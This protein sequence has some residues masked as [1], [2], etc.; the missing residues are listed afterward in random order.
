MYHQKNTHSSG[1]KILPQDAPSFAIDPYAASVNERET[2]GYDVLTVVAS[3]PD[4]GV[5]GHVTYSISAGNT[6]SAFWVDPT[7]GVVSTSNSRVAQRP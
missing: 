6:G 4:I 1:F 3:D 5:N 2:P 7:S